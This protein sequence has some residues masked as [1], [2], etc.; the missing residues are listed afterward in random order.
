[1]DKTL[2]SPKQVVG[3]NPYHGMEEFGQIFL[4]TTAYFLQLHPI[5]KFLKAFV[6]NEFH[7]IILY[8]FHVFSLK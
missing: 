6:I 3:S 1:M 4:Q 2:D 8:N 7:H 5:D